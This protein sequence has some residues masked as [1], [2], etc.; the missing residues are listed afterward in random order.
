MRH[1]MIMLIL[2]C[3]I[4]ACTFSQTNYECDSLTKLLEKV[5]ADDQKY[6]VD[7]WN[8]TIQKYG[9]N[10][11]EFLDL[12]KKMNSQDSIN[13]A[14]VSNIIDKYGWLGKEQ[15]SEEANHALSLVIQHAPLQ[16]QLKYLPILKEAVKTKKAKAT[17]Y[18]LL[19]D[20][21]NM[22]QGKFQIYGSQFYYDS[23]SNIHVYP[24]SNEPNVNKRRK[25][26]G[27][28]SMEEYIKM[29]D[30]TLTYRLPTTD[31]YKNK[32]LIRGSIEQKENNLPLA[33]ALIYTP[34]NNLTGSSNANGFF[35]II[36]DKKIISHSLCFKKEGFQSISVKIDAADKE[37][38]ELNVVLARTCR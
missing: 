29:V 22:Y 7:E 33:N 34:D 14:I 21:T 10:S 13:L 15:I 36:V 5:Y 27:L 18:A 30:T 8:S 12:I 11:E 17:E 19:V 26:V 20:R 31:A 23:K 4:P 35:Q 6:R 28:P 37:V 24:I 2:S 9:T 3:F 32:I 1:L 16:S 38:F 25:S